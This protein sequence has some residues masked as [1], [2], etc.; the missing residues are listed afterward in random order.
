MEIK[1]L[2][3]FTDEPFSCES[4]TNH[5]DDEKGNSETKYFEVNNKIEL[6]AKCED[7]N[8][9]IKCENENKNIN[10][11]NE[12]IKCENKN[13]TKDIS[14][15]NPDREGHGLSRQ[16]NKCGDCG[17]VF[18]KISSLGRHRRSKHEGVR[19][20]VTNVNFRQHNYLL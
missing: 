12:N 13:E 10:G 8:E 3:H 4:Y 11:E 2:S 15:F 9:D 7:E 16:S 19:F 20:S 6:D 5:A 18:G 17:S 1:E 14:L